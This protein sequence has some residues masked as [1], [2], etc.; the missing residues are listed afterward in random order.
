[1][2]YKYYTTS[3][4]DM[5]CLKIRQSYNIGPILGLYNIL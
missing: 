3:H 5:L 4:V 1:M 2:N